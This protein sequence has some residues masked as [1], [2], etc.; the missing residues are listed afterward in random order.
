MFT[1]AILVGALAAIAAAQSA[2]LTFTTVQNPITDGQ[3]TALLWATNDTVSVRRLR[4]ST[5][6]KGLS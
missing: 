3:P 1:K 4:A 6:S 2:V 5:Q